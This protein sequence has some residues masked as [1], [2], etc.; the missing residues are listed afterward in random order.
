MIEV[1]VRSSHLNGF[2]FP[3]A[4]VIKHVVPDLL[5]VLNI[6]LVSCVLICGHSFLQNSNEIIVQSIR[7]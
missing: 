4:L 1:C 6:K 2:E 7:S 5:A 3:Y